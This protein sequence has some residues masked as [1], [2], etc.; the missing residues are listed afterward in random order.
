MAS[1]KSP[2]GKL[3]QKHHR[4]PGPDPVKTPPRIGPRIAPIP[5][6]ALR[7][8]MYKP[9]SL[10]KG[11]NMR[12][13]KVRSNLLDDVP[14][15]KHIGETDIAENHNTAPSRPLKSSAGNE[16]RDTLG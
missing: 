8:L 6:A 3:I 12:R 1:E 15:T 10:S 13:T 5:P 9:R 11:Q 4:Q 16:H 7:A 14:Y 2:M